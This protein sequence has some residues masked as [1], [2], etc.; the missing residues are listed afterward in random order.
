M[1][2]T[3]LQEGEPGGEGA[4]AQNHHTGVTTTV[5]RRAEFSAGFQP[6][7]KSTQDIPSASNV[8]K[9]VAVR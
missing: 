7:A 9:T 6:L 5:C 1:R 2:K 3:R 4:F 8:L